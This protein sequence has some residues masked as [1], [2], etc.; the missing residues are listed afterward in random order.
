[1]PER[2]REAVRAELQRMIDNSKGVF[3]KPTYMRIILQAMNRGTRYNDLP[4]A[5]R[6]NGAAYNLEHVSTSDCKMIH[7][8]ILKSYFQGNLEYMLLHGLDRDDIQELLAFLN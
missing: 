5:L 6:A 8:E 3:E 4:E 1:M 7:G 2:D